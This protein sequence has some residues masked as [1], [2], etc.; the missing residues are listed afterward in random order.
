MI[1]SLRYAVVQFSGNFVSHLLLSKQVSKMCLKES[2]KKW[3]IIL[4]TLLEVAFVH[5]HTIEEDIK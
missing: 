2:I 5:G 3:S 4:H 1:C